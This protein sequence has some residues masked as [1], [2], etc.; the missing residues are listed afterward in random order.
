MEVS[1]QL[2]TRADSRLEKKFPHALNTKLDGPQRRF[3]HFG[4][5]TNFF[6][7]PAFDPLIA[8]PVA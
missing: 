7:L 3:G 6:P 1:G 8:H 2:H 4:E 5:E